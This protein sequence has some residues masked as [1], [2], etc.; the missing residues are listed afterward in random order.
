MNS[1]LNATWFETI[2]TSTVKVGPHDPLCNVTRLTVVGGDNV[3]IVEHRNDSISKMIWTGNKIIY[4]PFSK[5]CTSNGKEIC[6]N[7]LY[8]ISNKAFV[9]T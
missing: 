3:L 2:L 6:R 9:F 8:F 4:G 7:F 1:N 5:K